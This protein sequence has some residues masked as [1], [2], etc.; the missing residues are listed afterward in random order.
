MN[1]VFVPRRLDK[2]LREATALSVVEI[3]RA[4]AEGRVT[5]KNTT[6]ESRASLDTLVFENDWVSLD[7]RHVTPRDEH[8]Y[9]V[10]NKP[11]FV[12]S[13]ARDP[14]GNLDLRP[15]LTQMPEGVF[16]VGRLDRETSGLLIFTN[17]GSFANAVLQ[18]GHHTEKTYWLWLDEP[19]AEDDPR[20]HAFV[21]GVE[22]PNEREV[23]RATSIAIHHRAEDYTELIVTLD[24]GKNRH[25]RKMCNLLR[26]RLHELH[27][28]AIGSVQLG[29]LEL[30]QWRHLTSTEVSQL[31]AD[32]GGIE[33]VEAAKIAALTRLATEA[34]RRH[35]PL[36]RLEAW[37]TTLEPR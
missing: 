3:R 36:P 24:E 30:G 16:P 33:K 27:R 10:F 17:D 22:R 18:P 23:L 8:H 26:L 11:R 31:W 2:Y 4:W 28:K 6:D 19:L 12:T 1:A 5:V 32:N 29:S 9:L 25:I 21:T 7:G 37:L 14:E 34:S 15:W 20:L 35:A 13:T